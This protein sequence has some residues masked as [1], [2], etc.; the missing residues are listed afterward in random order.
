MQRDKLLESID[1][2]RPGRDDV[3]DPELAPLAAALRDDPAAQ[4][5][6]RRSQQFDAAARAAFIDVPVP[7]GLTDRLLHAVATSA[8]AASVAVGTPA[9][10]VAPAAEPRHLDRVLATSIS[11]REVEDKYEHVVT[12][13]IVAAA[14]TG[15][16]SRRV[17]RRWLWRAAIGCASVAVVA[18]VAVFF[19]VDGPRDPVTRDDLAASISQSMAELGPQWQAIDSVPS[20][21]LPKSGLL[22]PPHQWQALRSPLDRHAVVC[23]LS[24]K[25][26]RAY[27]V[28]LNRG[29]EFDLPAN[30]AR[31]SAT[32]GWAMWAWQDATH[33]YVLAVDEKQFRLEDFVRPSREVAFK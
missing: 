3:S 31:L 2:C 21:L 7:D 5:L 32:G 18:A 23:D 29:R 16:E 22:V 14:A 6:W 19:R 17:R 15:D 28:V 27:F 12:P 11:P 10:P 4:E 25:R 26:G 33:V 13:R 9:A 24:R 8:I 20:G 1:A 30:A